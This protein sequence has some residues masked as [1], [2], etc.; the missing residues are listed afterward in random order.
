MVAPFFWLLAL[1][2]A[3]FTYR[4]EALANHADLIATKMA[5]KMRNH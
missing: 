4:R 2:H 3:S 5:E 1:G